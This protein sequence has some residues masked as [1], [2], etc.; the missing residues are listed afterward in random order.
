MQ[1]RSVHLGR[2]ARYP[3][4]CLAVLRV[5]CRPLG[6]MAETAAGISR[7]QYCCEIPT[8]L[9]IGSCPKSVTSVR[10]VTATERSNDRWLQ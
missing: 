8:E 6:E 4:K 5:D 9:V 10:R 7:S 1:R 3:S 2:E